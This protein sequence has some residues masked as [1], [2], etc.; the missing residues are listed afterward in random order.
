MRALDAAT[1]KEIWRT[2]YPAPFQMMSSTARHGPGPKSTPTYADGR[3]FT[4]GMSSIV[5]AFDAKSGK[6]L[7]QHPKTA[8]QPRF[9]TA[10]SPAV[11]GDLVIVH[12]GGPGDAALTAFDAA[13]GKVRWQWDG[14]SPAYG[15]PLVVT[16]EG[17][18]Q[19]VTFTHAHLVGVAAADGALLWSRPFVT[20]SNTTAQTPILYRDTIV[21]AGRENGI[22]RFRAVRDGGGWTTKDLW[23]TDEVSLH[24]ANAV[25]VNGALYGLSH[26]NSGQYFA[27]D[28]ET[29]KVLWKSDPRQATNAAIVRAGDT[30]F[31]LEDDGELVIFKASRSAFEPVRRYEVAQ[32][33]TYAQ[34]TISGRRVFIKD[35]SKLTHWSFE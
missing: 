28:L 31:S 20:P 15:S 22:T 5:T 14:D 4:F 2:G 7:W 10:M 16:L 11:E 24:L 29:G 33:E 27:L 1:G 17:T 25:E 19:V 6:I 26:L 8:A 35:V 12:V 13:T 34:P 23:H 30:V 21:Q 32:S 9:H 18:R 3:L